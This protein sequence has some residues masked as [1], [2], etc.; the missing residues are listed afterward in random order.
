ME[1]VKALFVVTQ[2]YE[3]MWPR[4]S[5]IYFKKLLYLRPKLQ[6]MYRYVKYDRW[7]SHVHVR[8]LFIT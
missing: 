5:D 6:Y 8:K 1:N 7:K 2:K 4:I 3:H